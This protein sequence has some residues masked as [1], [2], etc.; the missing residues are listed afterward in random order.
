[1]ETVENVKTILKRL[2]GKKLFP[3][4]FH[5]DELVPSKSSDPACV[6]GWDEYEYQI[7]TD[8]LK[9]RTD[10]E[11]CAFCLSIYLNGK[12]ED[13]TDYIGASTWDEDDNE[14]EV[15]YS[16]YSDYDEAAEALFE[17][18]MQHGG[19]LDEEGSK[20]RAEYFAEW[21]CNNN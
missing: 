12:E 19:V 8:A 11:D 18:I 16:Q 10:E 17:L 7:G 3:I 4:A 15:D 13:T 2:E 9:L 6:D 1:M 21:G 20:G 14:I 5:I